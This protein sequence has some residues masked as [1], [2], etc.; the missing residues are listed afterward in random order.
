MTVV[1]FTLFP[2]KLLPGLTSKENI[3]ELDTARMFPPQGQ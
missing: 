2:N 1:E 3:Q